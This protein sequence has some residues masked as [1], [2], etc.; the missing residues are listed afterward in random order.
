MVEAARIEAT[1]NYK[2]VS[3]KYEEGL[4]SQVELIDAR[5]FMTNA[6]IENI[7]AKYDV[8]ISRAAYERAIAGYE[9]K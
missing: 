2:I 6:A 8:L 3:R 9:I 4:A 5:T 1:S 7:I